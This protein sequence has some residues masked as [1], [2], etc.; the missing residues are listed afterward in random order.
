MIK[1]F[2]YMNADIDANAATSVLAKVCLLISATF[3]YQSYFFAGEILTTLGAQNY[4]ISPDRSFA[5]TNISSF[6]IS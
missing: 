4:G 6:S 1:P 5:S 3:I 2:R